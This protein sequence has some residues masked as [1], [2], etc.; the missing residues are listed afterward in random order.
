M[1][2]YIYIYIRHSASSEGVFSFPA[3]LFWRL[4]S[5]YFPRS[6]LH[7]SRPPFWRCFFA[8]FS[9]SFYWGFVTNMASTCIQLG[10]QEASKIHKNRFKNGLYLGHDFRLNFYWFWEDVG[11]IFGGFWVPNWEANWLKTRSY[12]LCWQ[13]GRSSENASK[14]FL[15]QSNFP[16]EPSNLKSNV[17]NLAQRY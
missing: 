1:Y 8:L 5:V 17:E 6:A 2:I 10:S 3:S 15:F 13:V 14:R 9:K 4:F 16:V 7:S 12:G 11:W